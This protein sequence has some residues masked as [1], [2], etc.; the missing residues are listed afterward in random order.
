MLISFLLCGVFVLQ[1]VFLAPAR[2]D[3]RE[4]TLVVNQMRAIFLYNLTYF[5]RMPVVVPTSGKAFTIGILGHDPFG[6]FLDRIVAGEQKDNRP[7]RIRRYEGV[8]AFLEQPCEILYIHGDNM[9]SFQK[10]Q[11]HLTTKPVLTVSD[12]EKFLQEGGMVGLLQRRDDIQLEVNLTQVKLAQ[13][14]LSAK[15]LRLAKVKDEPISRG[16][17]P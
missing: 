12:N 4:G 8:E 10:V 14:T 9:I 7:I 13:L 17:Q 3:A 15:L 1:G 6:P 16:G 11:P 2:S 5:V